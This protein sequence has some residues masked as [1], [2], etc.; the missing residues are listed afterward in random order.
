MLTTLEA[1]IVVKLVVLVITKS[2]STCTNCGKTTRTL[3]TC[4]KWK[5]EIPIVPTAMVK[6]TKPI[7]ETKSQ[8]VK[9]AR[10]LIRY[11]Y[12]ICYSAKHRSKECPRKIEVQNMFRTKSVSS[13]LQQHLNSFNLI[14]Y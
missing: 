5:R 1:N 9:L 12:I 8:P 3:E 11:P 7:I 14:I 10:I 2:T 4:H 6:P 13:M